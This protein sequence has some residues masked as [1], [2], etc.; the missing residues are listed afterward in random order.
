M[1]CE[2]ESYGDSCQA[3]VDS[4]VRSPEYGEGENGQYRFSP[5]EVRHRRR[6]QGLEW[7]LQ[8][9]LNERF[10]RVW[11]LLDVHNASWMKPANGCPCK[12]AKNVRCS[13]LCL[14]SRVAQ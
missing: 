7:Y 12:L 10:A 9:M 6:I 11:V 2:S 13:L 8:G 4:L 14:Y 5:L 1:G 3:R